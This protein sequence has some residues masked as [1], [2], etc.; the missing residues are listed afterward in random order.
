M[1]LI[2]WE[3][4]R[5]V[6]SLQSEMN[7]VFDAFFGDGAGG[8]AAAGGP[9][10]RRWIP[11]M[12]LVE[13]EERYV[14]RADLP[15]LTAEDVDLQMEDGVLTITGERK[16]AH[17]ARQGGMVR[18]ERAYGQFSRQLTLPEG[19]DPEAVEADFEHGVLEIRVPKP[20]AKQPRKVQI[21]VGKQQ[22]RTIEGSEAS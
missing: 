20:A 8:Q 3:P 7:R 16:A 13:E 5:E 14:L 1:A 17:E 12:D 2:R 22:T 10:A 19:V 9:P 15:G 11:A 21:G 6:A 4:V 18:I